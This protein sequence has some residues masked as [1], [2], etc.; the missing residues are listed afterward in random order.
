MIS[1]AELVTGLDGTS[2]A[3]SEI[4]MPVTLLCTTKK[5]AP[6]T[7]YKFRTSPSAALTQPRRSKPV[8]SGYIRI[9][10]LMQMSRITRGPVTYSV[11]SGPL[12]AYMW[13]S[14][15]QTQ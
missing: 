3:I 8:P 15:P 9:D 4:S 14:D 13:G 1:I 12:K 5:M 6:S 7:K 2:G 11:V 10:E